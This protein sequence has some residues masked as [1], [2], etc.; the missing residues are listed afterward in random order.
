LNLRPGEVHALVGENGAG[1]STLIKVLSGAVTPDSGEVIIEGISYNE[2]TPKLSSSLGVEV[3]YQ[4]LN[5]ISYLTVSENIFLGK[6]LLNGIFLDYKKMNEMTKKLVNSLGLDMNPGIKIKDLTVAYQ[7]LVEVSKA[8]AQNV[9]ILVMDEPTSPLSNS[10]VKALFEL[11]KKLKEQGVAIIYI[12]HRLEEIFEIC[13]RITVMRDGHYIDTLDI[14]CTDRKKL[15]NMMV[16]RELVDQYPKAKVIPGEVIMSVE[17]LENQSVKNITFELKK[18]E[19]LGIAGLVGAGRTEMVRTIFGADRLLKGKIIIEGKQVK[20]DSPQDA[21]ALGIGL[22]PEDRKSQ[23]L[24]LGMS[25]RENAT[26]ANLKSLIKYR[27]ISSK[28]EKQVVQN[29]M[30]ELRIKAPDQDKK[31]KLLSGGNQQKVVLAKW[32]STNSKILIFDEPTRGID[33][34]AKHEI[35]ELMRNLTLQGISIIMISSEM[36]ELLGMSDRILVMHGGEIM[37]SFNRGEVSQEQI[38]DLASGGNMI[39]EVN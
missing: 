26:L 34:G 23:G 24:I 30:K 5:L 9:K 20:I 10:E 15:I 16:G 37:G 32:M 18:G 13:D 39:K 19:I 29:F 17:G 14:N 6:E 2:M 38:L 1:K 36:P 25:I 35:Y 33:V 28:K 11:I 27:L 3:I 7:Q 8:V 31:V 22:I 21:I 12:S 4:E